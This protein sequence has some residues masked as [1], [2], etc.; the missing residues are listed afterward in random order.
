MGFAQIKGPLT[1]RIGRPVTYSAPK[2]VQGKGGISAKGVII[3]EVWADETQN[4]LPPRS[5]GHPHDWG[6]YSFCAQLIKWDVI[7]QLSLLRCPHIRKASTSE[8]CMQRH[9]NE[10]AA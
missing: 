2:D 8:T 3:D 7:L 9:R 1:S 6:D 5:A 10:R 4:H